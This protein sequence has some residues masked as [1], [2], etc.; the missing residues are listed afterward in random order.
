MSQIIVSCGAAALYTSTQ[1]AV[2]HSADLRMTAAVAAATWMMYCAHRWIGL[3]LHP[4]I[5][6]IPRFH[7]VASRSVLFLSGAILCG[8]YLLVSTPHMIRTLGWPSLLGPV[9]ISALYSLPVIGSRRL[10]DLPYIKIFVIAAIWTWIT[11]LWPL[12][13]QSFAHVWSLAAACCLF[14]IAITIPFDIRDQLVDQLSKLPTLVTVLGPESA[15]RLA[16]GLL[17]IAGALILYSYTREIVSLDYALALL[18]TYVISWRLIVAAD[19]T[20]PERYYSGHIDGV[21]TIPLIA[22]FLISALLDMLPM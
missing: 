7:Y 9:M 3:R 4:E 5:K 17:L 21:M 6:D 1:L 14:I 16:A 2:A 13:G 18:I 22:Y 20:R 8:L 12:A 11:V 15:K 19:Q 10:R